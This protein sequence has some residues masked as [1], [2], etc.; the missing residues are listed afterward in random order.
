VIQLDDGRLCSV[1]NHS[2]IVWSESYGRWS[3]AWTAFKGKAPLCEISPGVIA[4]CSS[5]P[6]SNGIEVWDLSSMTLITTLPG[7]SSPVTFLLP[8]KGGRL[9]SCSID[10][11]LRIWDIDTSECLAVLVGHNGMISHVVQLPDGRLCSS[12]HDCTIRIWDSSVTGHMDVEWNEGTWKFKVLRIHHF[13]FPSICSV[14]ILV[15][16]RTG[17]FIFN[18]QL[19]S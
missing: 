12:S 2:I 13:H 1:G 6:G 19:C 9:C 8:L 4:I 17:H 7:H 15:S 5:S 11:T 14:L 10:K 3:C 16:L 18:R